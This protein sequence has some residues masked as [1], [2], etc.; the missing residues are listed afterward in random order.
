MSLIKNAIASIE[1][2]L[3]DFNSGDDKRLISSVRNCYAGIMLLFKAM[4]LSLSPPGSNDVLLKQQVIPKKDPD[5]N[6]IFVGNGKKTVDFQQ[7]QDRFKQLG[8]RADWDRM[9]KINDIRNDMEHYHCGASRDAIRGMLSDTFLVV[10]DFMTHELTEDPMMLLSEGAWDTLL[11]VSEVFEKEKEE[12]VAK[13][14]GIDWESEALGE[15]ILGIA[16]NACGSQLLAPS[17]SGPYSEIDLICRS[18]GEIEDSESFIPR[19][20]S[21]H[22][23]S[24][25]HFAVKDGGEDATIMCPFCFTESYV[26]DEHRCAHCGESATHT[27][28]RCGTDIPA[29]EISDGSLCGWCEHMPCKDD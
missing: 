9:K 18:C 13:L 1:L 11:S 2:G 17:K 28:K 7:I 22:F 24:A 25:N 20:I 26:M 21:D 3:D 4:L 27:C 10:R 12:S 5:G 19:A 14:E 8:I 23:T 16:C 6:L 29:S 15:A